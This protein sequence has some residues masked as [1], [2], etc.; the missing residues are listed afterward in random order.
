MLED[1]SIWQFSSGA[2]DVIITWSRDFDKSSYLHLR[3]GF[4]HQPLTIVTPLWEES[5]VYSLKVFVT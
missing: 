5:R 3:I 4:S 2:G 1:E